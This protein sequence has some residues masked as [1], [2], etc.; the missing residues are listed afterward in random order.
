MKKE[1]LFFIAVALIVGVLVGVL[2]SKGGRG[3]APV[4]GAAPAAPAA[5]MQ[6]N[7]QLMEKMVAAE[8]GNRGA[9]VQLGNAY[10]DSRQPVQAIE[11]Y[12]RALELD[13]NDPDV[14]TDQG[15]MF[16]EMKWYDRAIEN[17]NKANEL[18]P[19]H[20]QSL[21]NLGVVYRYDL[22][23]LNRA[24]EVWTRYLEINPSGP[25][26]D[27]IRREMEALGGAS[28]FPLPR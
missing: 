13:P 15:V 16:R 5:N 2:V 8:P 25:G 24:R 22:N 23:D 26:A 6:Q 27:Q 4:Q 14:L 1:T 19:A 21:Y 7:I 17:F 9:W 11:A 3:S 20:P 12:N 18:N 10:F 28:T